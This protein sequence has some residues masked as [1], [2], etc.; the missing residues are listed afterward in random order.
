MDVKLES[1][2]FLVFPEIHPEVSKGDDNVNRAGSTWK[3]RDGIHGYGAH[4]TF[5]VWFP[6]TEMDLFDVFQ[7][8]Y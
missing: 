6:L 4:E 5:F 3:D 1:L 7:D 2:L 8:I